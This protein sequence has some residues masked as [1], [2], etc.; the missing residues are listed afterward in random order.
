M[1]TTRVR[2]LMRPS[3]ITCP[4]GTRLA[5][6]ARILTRHQVH[7]LVV[8]DAAGMPLG[9]L[10][11][12]A[13][14]AGDWLSGDREAREQTQALT[15]GEVMTAPAPVIDAAAP[16]R[17]AAARLCAEGLQRLVV[18]DMERAVGVIS[19]SDLV[20][21]LLPH[22]GERR[23]V[24]EAMSRGIVVCRADTTV[25][26][27]ARAMS[28]H[29]SRSLVVVGPHG[30]PLGVVTGYDLLSYVEAGESH[31]P[32]SAIMHP[33]VTID[34]AAALHE[35][36]ALMRERGLHRLLVVDPAEPGSMPLG[37]IS[38]ADI[39]VELAGPTP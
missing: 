26:A 27:A 34:P 12:I 33:P 35:A 37:Q 22:A 24:S 10:P 32:V 2:D 29:R 15:A 16:A 23:R 7:A 1:L 17:A 30:Q 28:E 19:V 6:A 13:L 38:T 9:L 3:L 14:L 36:A 11:D 21:G 8:A 5:E 18:T 31:D 4:P 39:I 25:S 20:Q